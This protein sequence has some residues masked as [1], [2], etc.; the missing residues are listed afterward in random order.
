MSEKKTEAWGRIL[1]VAGAPLSD[2]DKEILNLEETWR[3]SFAT[4]EHAIRSLGM[5]PT[6]YYIH[7]MNIVKNPRAE[8]EYPEIVRRIRTLCEQRGRER[9]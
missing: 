8:L 3:K 7:L 6:Q 1:N 9:R 2:L 5:I 4:K